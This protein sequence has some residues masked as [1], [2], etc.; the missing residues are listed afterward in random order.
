VD[1]FEPQEAMAATATRA[2]ASG[3]MSATERRRLPWD[4][5]EAV[6][7]IDASHSL[8]RASSSAISQAI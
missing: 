3:T 5:P 4:W 6:A 1:T 2:T 8:R 7:L